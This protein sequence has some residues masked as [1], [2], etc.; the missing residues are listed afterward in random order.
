MKSSAR[1]MYAITVFMFV[2]TI[3]YILAT[4]HVGD[5]GSIQGLEWA[6]TV[7][8]AVATLLT[9]FLGAYFHITE[10]HVDILPNDWEEAEQAD[11][12]GE[13]GFFSPFSI[14][15][16]AMTGGIAILGYG[17]VFMAYWMIVTGAV[18]LV[19]AT[20]MLQLQYL[21]PMEKH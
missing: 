20:L 5:D 11:G 3:I 18:V 12:A 15:P 16:L 9:L 13:L 21:H 6:G 14:W 4:R 8:L 2:M 10:R 17:V 19:W 1:L 7:G